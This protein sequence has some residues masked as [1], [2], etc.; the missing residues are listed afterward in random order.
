MPQIPV[1]WATTEEPQRGSL[2]PLLLLALTTA[3]LAFCGTLLLR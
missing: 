1:R 3:I 2:K